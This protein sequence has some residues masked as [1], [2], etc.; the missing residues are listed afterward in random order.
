[1]KITSE[2][3]QVSLTLERNFTLFVEPFTAGGVA[4]VSQVLDVRFEV[5]DRHDKA[6]NGHRHR[7]GKGQ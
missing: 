2:I 6:P 7:V 3:S 4:S 1:M 5:T